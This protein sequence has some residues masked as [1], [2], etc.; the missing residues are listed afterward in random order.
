MKKALL[1]LAIVASGLVVAIAQSSTSLSIR[2]YPVQIIELES[3]EENGFFELSD[4]V[5]VNAF[6][7]SGYHV[8]VITVTENV[9]NTIEHVVNPVKK[10]VDTEIYRNDK[11][12]LVTNPALI[13][14][15]LPIENTLE[16]RIA[17][18][19]IPDIVY[20]IEAL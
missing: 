8:N 4:E 19:N 12:D 9:H 18:T 6:S 10:I 11:V 15:I 5:T 14:E 20:S 2:L 1:T 16:N 3:I 17:F 13:N 7:T